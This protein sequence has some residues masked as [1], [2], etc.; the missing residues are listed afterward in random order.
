MFSYVVLGITALTVTC[1]D[2]LKKKFNQRCDT[3]AFLFGGMIS[4]FAMI[5]FIA[6][7]RDWNYDS[8]Q[9]LYSSLFAVAYA[10]T[11]MCAVLAIKYGSLAKTSLIVSCSLL[12]PSVYG[13]LFLNEPIGPALILG[14]LLLVVSLVLINYEKEPTRVTLKWFLLV[15]IAFIGNGMCSVVQKLEQLRFGS[16]GQNL[17]MIVALAMVTLM[18]VT[19][20]FT[21]VEERARRAEIIKRGAMFAIPCGL[22]NGLC[23]FLVLY[24][25]PR[26]PASVMFPVISAGSVVLVF[27]YATLVQHEKFNFKQKIGYALGVVAIVLLNL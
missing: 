21:S 16:T 13:M 11:T 2:V 22:F 17:F 14:T 27:L 20:S 8:R 12:V 5:F 23:N 15:G 25:N 24:L 4:L 7:N 19:L 6:V 9:L 18:L 3:G 1:Q 10:V 26:L